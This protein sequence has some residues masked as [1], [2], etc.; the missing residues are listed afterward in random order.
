MP[1]V[2]FSYPN[3]KYQGGNELYCVIKIFLYLSFISFIPILIMNILIFN[4]TII[5]ILGF[6]FSILFL[7]IISYIIYDYNKEFWNTFLAILA[8][9]MARK[10]VRIFTKK[11]I[12]EEI[13]NGEKYYYCEIP[14]FNNNILE[15]SRT[16]DFK[17][18][19]VEMNIKEHNFKFYYKPRKEDIKDLL[20]LI[21]KKKVKKINKLK[22]KMKEEKIQEELNVEYWYARFYFDKKPINGYMRV[23][24]N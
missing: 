2:Y 17:K 3:Y 19:N 5:I 8:G 23:I 1:K 10:K 6:I 24:Y 4:F 16:K 14:N 22:K 7:F 12:K 15:Y 18:Y 21:K 11:D 9:I 20:N 13:T